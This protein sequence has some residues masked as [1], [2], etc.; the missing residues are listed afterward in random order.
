MSDIA[1]LAGVSRQAL[2]LHF[3]S[4]AELLVATTQY[5]DQIRGLQERLAPWLAATT[6]L[7]L[8][9]E[10]VDFW[11]N[12]LPEIY[13]IA[14]ALF[15]NRETDEAAATAWNERMEAVRGSCRRTIE[16]LQKDGMLA[17]EWNSDEATNLMWTTLSIP[18]WEQF[19]TECGWSTSQYISRMQMLL[20]NTL[21][22]KSE[23]S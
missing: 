7:E 23:D 12:Y 2:Y 22:R 18:N 9:M 15:L 20:K 16:A 19:T 3:S 21:V 17:A 8:L 10:F 11:G 4:R 13:G 1:A 6:G 5:G 14:K